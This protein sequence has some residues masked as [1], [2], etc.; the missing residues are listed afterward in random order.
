MTRGLLRITLLV[1]A[2]MALSSPALALGPVDGEVTALYWMSKT[3]VET[4]EDVEGEE[5]DS[6]DVGGRAE[7]WFMKKFGVSAAMYG[8]DP[9][10]TLE[11]T[12]IDQRQLDVKWRLISPTENNF[13]AIGAGWQQIDFSGDIDDETSGPRLV[14]EGRLGLVGILY[15]YGR[16]AY[17]PDL[18][19]FTIDDV[20]LTDGSGHEIEAGVQ[21]KPFPFIQVFAGWRQTG[22]TFD[23]PLGDELEIDSSGPVAG[24]GINF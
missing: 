17:L 14:V 12:D 20:P 5:E 16:G 2:T 3:E 19:D 21:L 1:L 6:E 24:V 13:L 22:M 9:E 7:L 4:S 15:A 18:D 8:I 11:G 10:G 23:T